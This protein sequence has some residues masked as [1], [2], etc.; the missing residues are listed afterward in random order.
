MD[1]KIHHLNSVFSSA[2]AFKVISMILGISEGWV[3]F[4]VFGKN[5]MEEKLKLGDDFLCTKGCENGS[6][7]QY[8]KF[9]GLKPL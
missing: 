1:V 4:I 5:I 3:I 6:Y 7:F 8:Y 9:G 2:G